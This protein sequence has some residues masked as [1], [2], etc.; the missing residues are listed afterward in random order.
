[1]LMYLQLI[2]HKNLATVSNV[3]EHYVLVFK[4]LFLITRKQYIFET[5][6]TIFLFKSTCICMYIILIITFLHLI[7]GLM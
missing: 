7:I 3:F 6:L 1:M 2:W 5:Y 4:I